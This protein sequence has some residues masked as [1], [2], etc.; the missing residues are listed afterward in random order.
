MKELV[1]MIGYFFT[2]FSAFRTRNSYCNNKYGGHNNPERHY[3]NKAFAK[4]ESRSASLVRL[5][6]ATPQRV[7]RYGLELLPRFAAS[8]KV[9]FMKQREKMNG[10][11]HTISLSSP[12]TEREIA[13]RLI[14]GRVS[15][16]IG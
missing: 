7:Q 11:R 12:E 1:R 6:R 16:N 2:V 9:I 15:D 13:Q 5:T 14:R 4:E 3:E 8:Q 10:R